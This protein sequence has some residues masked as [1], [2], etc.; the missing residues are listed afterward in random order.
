M[1]SSEPGEPGEPGYDLRRAGHEERPGGL[2]KIA[3]GVDVNEDVG[4]VEHEPDSTL[5]DQALKAAVGR[6][7][8]PARPLRP[9]GLPVPDHGQGHRRSPVGD[10]AGSGDPAERNKF[11]TNESRSEGGQDQL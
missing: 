3:L 8:R 4:A 1:V 6:V 11:A 5:M 2:E 7:S 9:P 10:K